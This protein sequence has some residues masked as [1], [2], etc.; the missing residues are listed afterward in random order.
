[1]SENKW[2]NGPWKH[3]PE[4]NII[5]SNGRMI[6]EWQARSLAV[7]VAERDANARLIAAAPDLAEA[8]ELIVGA[9][10]LSKT[11]DLQGMLMYADGIGKARA[12]LAKAR[13]ES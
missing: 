1:M 4:D 2:T 10:I 5:V 6:L 13:G 12:A 7:S 9:E 8:C 11:D 3:Y